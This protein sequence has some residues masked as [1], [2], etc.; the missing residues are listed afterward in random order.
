MLKFRTMRQDESGLR[1]TAKDDQRIT[2]AGRFLR[3]TKLDELPELWNV[4]RGDMSLVGPRPEVPD[5]VDLTS[6]SWKMVLNSRPGISDPV[7]VRLRNEED[8]LAS[9]TTDRESYLP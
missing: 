1:V 7:T 9:V 6:H 2:L 8:L 3:Q 4:V 5:F